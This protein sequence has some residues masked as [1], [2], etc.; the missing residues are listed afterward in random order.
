[1]NKHIRRKLILSLASL[2]S[3]AICLSSTTYAWFAKNGDAWVEKTTIQLKL[4]EALEVSLDGVNFAQDVTSDELKKY[5]SG[6]VERFNQTAFQGVSIKQ[7]NSLVE[8]D[9]YEI[10]G[11]ED[12]YLK[13]EYD[14]VNTQTYVRTWLDARPN[15]D[16]LVFNLW[17]KGLNIAGREQDYK[18]KFGQTTS[19]TS[20]TEE[21]RLHKGFNTWDYNSTLGYYEPTIYRANDTITQNVSNA[22]RVGISNKNSN[23]PLKIFE[24][25]DDLDNGS[26]AINGRTDKKHD[27]YS[28]PMI[29]Y[30]NAYF[31][32]YPLTTENLDKKDENDNLLTGVLGATDGEAFNTINEFGHQDGDLWVGQELGTF[33]N[34]DILKVTVYIW[35]E[36]WDADYILGTS[37]QASQF[38]IK[39]AFDLVE[40]H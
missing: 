4:D 13:F 12:S 37:K 11:V 38:D 15:V 27:P 26:A 10:N 8:Y 5:I 2:A 21:V 33:D 32:N 3:T 25:Y 39:L 19:V 14:N 29:N 40:E 23:N 31:P 36:G 9:T 34:T 30:Y 22:V 1:M 35:V 24:V 7:N 20:E 17:L 28:S 18:I 6:S 16:Y